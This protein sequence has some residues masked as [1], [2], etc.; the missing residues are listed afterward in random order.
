MSVQTKALG[1]E[2]VIPFGPEHPNSIFNRIYPYEIPSK[3]FNDYVKVSEKSYDKGE[4][5]YHYEYVLPNSSHTL[6]ISSKRL[7]KR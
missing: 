6:T 2:G 5:K 3:F 4:Y 1:Q 7:V